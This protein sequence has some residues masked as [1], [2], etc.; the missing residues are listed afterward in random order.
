MPATLMGSIVMFYIFSASRAPRILLAVCFLLA[1]GYL[2][3]S[4]L[5][6]VRSYL[7]AGTNDRSAFGLNA[8]IIGTI[9]GLIPMV[10][11]LLLMVVAPGLGLPGLTCPP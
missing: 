2:A 5:M 1:I 11:P 10:I 6:V 9:I 8:M 3:I 4:A 7:A